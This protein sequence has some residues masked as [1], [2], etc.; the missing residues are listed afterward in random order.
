LTA[1]GTAILAIVEAIEEGVNTLVPFLILGWRV[2]ILRSGSRVSSHVLLLRE[3]LVL[4]TD[5][6]LGLLLGQ[7]RRWPGRQRWR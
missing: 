6:L 3:W 7:K 5:L 4:L 1:S 2:L